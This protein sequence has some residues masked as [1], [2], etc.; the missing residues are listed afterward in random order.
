MEVVVIR[1]IVVQ[2]HIN[3]MDQVVGL[4]KLE[5]NKYCRNEETVLLDYNRTS[6]CINTIQA[7]NS[8]NMSLAKEQVFYIFDIKQDISPSKKDV[9]YTELWAGIKVYETEQF[10]SLINMFVNS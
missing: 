9:N 6:R 10:I 8:I 3:N 5:I 1:A 4:P 7:N 2:L